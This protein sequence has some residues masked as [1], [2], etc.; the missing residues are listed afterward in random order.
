[1][2]LLFMGSVLLWMLSGCAA[3]VGDSGER[4]NKNGAQSTALLNPVDACGQTPDERRLMQLVNGVRS[5]ALACNATLTQLARAK[6]EA[7]CRGAALYGA[8]G[9]THGQTGNTPT[10]RVRNAGIATCAAGENINLIPKTKAQYEAYLNTL[11]TRYPNSNNIVPLAEKFLRSWLA[12]ADHHLNI[13]LRHFVGTGLAMSDCTVSTSDGP[14]SATVV[15]QL[16]V[17]PAQCPQ[18]FDPNNPFAEQ[19]RQPPVDTASP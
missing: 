1:M 13:K 6:S 4:E 14:K 8:K 10:G 15:T 18:G 11:R 7:E 12:S 19:R 17:V 16:F 5:N 9:V 2:P 3:N